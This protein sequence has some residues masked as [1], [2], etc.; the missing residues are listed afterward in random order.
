[1]EISISDNINKISRGLS[2]KAKRQ[3]PFAISQTLNKLAFEAQKEEKKQAPKYLHKPTPFTLAGFRYK[4]SNKRNLT[5]LVYV[6]AGDRR[7]AY[8]KFAIVG[9]ESK[10]KNRVLLHPTANTKLN[11]YGNIPR[12]YLKNKLA[13]KT[14]FFLGTPKGMQGKDNYGLW[15][16]HGGK[17]GGQKQRLR[18]MATFVDSRRYSAVFPFYRITEGVVKAKANIIFNREFD[19]AMKTAR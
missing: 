6:D 9:G 11:K 4:K 12:N 1:M 14:K 7:R 10:P 15:E 5:S 18:M 13:N 8:L 3:L 17:R 16:R 2:K 19:K